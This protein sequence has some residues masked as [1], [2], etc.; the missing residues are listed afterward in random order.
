MCVRIYLKQVISQVDFYFQL[1]LSFLLKLG[2]KS[3]FYFFSQRSCFNDNCF[4]GTNKY[5]IQTVLCI[6]FFFKSFFFTLLACPMTWKYPRFVDMSQ[7]KMSK[8]KMRKISYQIQFLMIQ[9][10]FDTSE[11]TPNFRSMHFTQFCSL[12]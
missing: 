11:I 4:N 2:N 8:T 1:N 3:L 10:Y 7:Q 9:K 6:S 12:N 5:Y